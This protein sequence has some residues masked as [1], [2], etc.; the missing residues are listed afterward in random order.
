MSTGTH[1]NTSAAQAV[2]VKARLTR[3]LGELQRAAAGAATLPA[4]DQGHLLDVAIGLDQ[5]MLALQDAID[6]ATRYIAATRPAPAKFAGYNGG[7]LMNPLA[8]IQ[9]A[10]RAAK[11]QA[12][13]EAT[14]LLNECFA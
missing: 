9:E 8:R 14:A 13:A 5:A 3:D 1:F 6:A 4:D 12:A 10:E 2:A 7:P 11:L